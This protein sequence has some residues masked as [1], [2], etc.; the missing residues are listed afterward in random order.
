MN[1]CVLYAFS[2]FPAFH[3]Y[4]TLFWC[5]IGGTHPKVFVTI[6]SFGSLMVERVDFN[7]HKEIKGHFGLE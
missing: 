3:I 2:F 7:Q 4:P 1:L 5:W 6:F